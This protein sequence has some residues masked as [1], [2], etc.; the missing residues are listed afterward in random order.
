MTVQ[1][2]SLSLN[3]ILDLLVHY[4]CLSHFQS[5]YRNLIQ[6]LSLRLGCWFEYRW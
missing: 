2:L 4:R 3:Q 6:I 5:R 1:I